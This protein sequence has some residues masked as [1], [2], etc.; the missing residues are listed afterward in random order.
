MRVGV[1]GR[2][3]HVVVRCAPVNPAAPAQL[4]A[5]EAR[6]LLA[7][8]SNPHRPPN[9][10]CARHA[11]WAL[12]SN[13]QRPP[14]LWAGRTEN[15][16]RAPRRALRVE[17]DRLAVVACGVLGV[18]PLRLE[19]HRE[20]VVRVDVGFFVLDTRTVARLGRRRDRYF[21]VVTRPGLLTRHAIANS[22]GS[23]PRRRQRRRTAPWRAA[24]R[25]CSAARRDECAR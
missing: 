22:R 4:S 18:A 8:L 14:Q 19:Q 6:H 20:R 12:P 7:L 10:R 16:R 2:A 9:S 23:P 24:C 13:Q 3:R 15:N 5:R 17:L 1:P 21:S 11:V 25:G